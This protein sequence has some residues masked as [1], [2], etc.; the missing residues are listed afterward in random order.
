MDQMFVVTLREGIE[1]FLIVAITIAYLRKTGRPALLSPVW[2][3]VGAAALL[4]IMLGAFLAEY[5]VQPVWEGALAAA[6]GAFVVTMVVYMMRTA[7]HLRAEI[8]NR[9]EAAAG[10]PGRGPWIGIFLFVLLMITREGMEMA[11]ITAT[12]ARQTGSA[13]LLTGATAGIAAAA[14]LAWA[15]SR[16]GHR[17]NLALFFQVTSIFLLLFAAQLFLYSFHEFTEAAVL[18]LDNRYWHD[19]TEAWAE[20]KY[21]QI[22]T[23]GLVLLPLAW[24]IVAHLRGRK[25]AP[26]AQAR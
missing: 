15:W 13:E 10:E 23:W 8:G 16:Y 12:L 3:G 21:A 25:T 11:L 22:V 17:V 2:W 1:A 14:G 5:A 6:A 19:A 20:G 26:A 7:K 18:P 9:V 4:S 24:L